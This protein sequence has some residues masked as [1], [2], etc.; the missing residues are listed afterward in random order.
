MFNLQFTKW[1]IEYLLFQ[2][3]TSRIHFGE[4]LRTTVDHVLC[5]VD[6]PAQKCICNET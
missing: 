5:L 6:I 1:C 2:Q 4:F 3:L